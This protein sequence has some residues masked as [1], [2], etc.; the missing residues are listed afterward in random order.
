MSNLDVIRGRQAVIPLTNKSGGGVV[1]GDLVIIDTSTDESFTTTSTANAEV[2]IGIV[3]ETIAN[4]ASGRVLVHGFAPLV[5]TA[6]VSVTR[7]N[8]MFHSSNTKTAKQNA[9][10][11]AGAMGQFLS[12]S[13]TPK[14]WIWGVGDQTA[15]GGLGAWTS[16]TPTLTAVTTNPTLGNSTISG[17]YKSLD[18]TTYI[19]VVSLAI[20][21]TFSAGSGEYKFSLPSGVTAGAVSQVISCHVLDSGTARYAGI[22]LIVGGLTVIHPLVIA[23]ATG[24]RILSH[25]VPITWATGDA[26]ELTGTFEAA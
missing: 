17:R 3:Q 13:T 4:N 15:G 16:Y 25:N 11:S 5:N 26:I 1:A 8:Y 14:G 24:T 2:S 10:R 20:G 23:D 9:T 21:S 12:T 18:S 22:G 19:V 6:A 7:G